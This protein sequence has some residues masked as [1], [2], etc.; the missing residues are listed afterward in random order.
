MSELAVADIGGT[1]ARFAMARIDGGDIVLGEAVVFRTAE[2]PGLAEA[3]HAFLQRADATPR[4]AAI[5]AAGPLRRGSITLTNAS[6]VIDAKALSALG[7]ERITLLNDFA[8]VAHGVARLPDEAFRHLAGPRRPLPREGTITVLGPGTGLGVAALHRDR[9][10]HTVL[11]GEGGHI[12]FAPQDALEDRVLTDLRAAY[13]R[14]VSEHVTAAR[15]ILAIHAALGGASASDE[16]ALWQAALER[17]QPRPA[18][19]AER[20]LA[21]LGAAAGD[22]ALIHGATGVVLAGALANRLAALLPGSDF[23][24]RFAAKPRYEA[25]MADIPVKLLTYPQP[26]LLGAAA[27]F[28]GEHG[29]G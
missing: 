26:G 3:W 27:A 6:W 2:F 11:A 12:G 29:A 20:Y 24:A 21:A 10:G 1:H 17:G 16:R 7:L 23:A 5:A 15:G 9:R 19:A 14:P 28:L 18:A 25:L 4:W 13:P 22:Y 8:A